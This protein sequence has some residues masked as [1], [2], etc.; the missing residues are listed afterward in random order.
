MTSPKTFV[1]TDERREFRKQH[2]NTGQSFKNVK[3]TPVHHRPG[4]GSS[5]AHFA[6]DGYKTMD[7]HVSEL[8]PGSHNNRHRH[9]N[10]AIILILFGKGHTILTSPEGKETRIDWGAGDIFSPP[11]NWWHQHF[12]DDPDKPA[13]YLAA[14]N[15]PLMESMGVF[16]KEQWKDG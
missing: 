3:T 9:T 13:R 7:F 14:T 12:N 15:V 16:V 11:L 8:A 10:E 1:E 6:I 5:S 2:L 4:R